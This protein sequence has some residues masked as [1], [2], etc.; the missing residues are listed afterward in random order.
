M[1][2][3][4]ARRPAAPRRQSGFTWRVLLGLAAMLLV[5]RVTPAAETPN[6][7]LIVSDDQGSDDYSFLGHPHIRTPR[8][9]RLASESLTFRNAYS[10][11]S[12]CRPSLVTMLTG[13]Y[14]HQ[15]AITSND[16][17][18]PGDKKR[19]AEKDPT[20]LAQRQQMIAKLDACATLPGLLGKL[21]YASFQTGKWWEGDFRRGR[22]TAGMSLGGRHGDA[23][24]DIGRKTMQPMYDFI[25]ASVAARQPF[26]LWYAP[27][28]PHTPH[29]PPAE[30]LAKYLPLAPN[31][32]VAKYWANVE[33]FD[34]TC[35]ELL[36]FLDQ[37]KLS[38]NT[39]VIYVTDNGWIQSPTVNKYAARSKQ[40]QY[41]GGL[42][43][44]LMLRWPGHIK[45]AKS[46]QRVLTIDIAP[47]VLK[48]VGL[49]RMPTMQG[50][51]LLD[52]SA[53]DERRT[54]YGE[55]FTHNAVD[56]N[57]PSRNLRWRWCIANNLKLIVPQ[58]SNEEGP[59]ELYDLTK[60]PGETTNLAHIEPKRVAELRES[61]DA[62]WPATE[63]ATGA[64]R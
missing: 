26:F 40:S 49:D 30:L 44:P 31:E 17:P 33:R 64:S 5:A 43:T 48:I 52:A 42:R 59:I 34:T 29:D 18:L 7:V 32:A 41:D 23:G 47:T 56:V 45:P 61:L 14:P 51:D 55:C 3:V 13:L 19:N 25:D 21:N 57:V 4:L 54:I 35:G 58:P 16:P 8:L 15:H 62:W 11:C 28:L 37:R 6:V 50:V 60:D 38:D 27:M 36:D 10:P 22:F 9:D 1:S 46:D 53:R 63:P 2:P 39:L 20:F 12:L 24:L